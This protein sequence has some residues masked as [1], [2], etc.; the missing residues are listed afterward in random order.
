MLS[1][2]CLKTSYN[3][4]LLRQRVLWQADVPVATASRNILV[5][6]KI[7]QS[8]TESLCPEGHDFA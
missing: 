6:S 2:E 3:A 4:D 7:A 8:D 1:W 5:A